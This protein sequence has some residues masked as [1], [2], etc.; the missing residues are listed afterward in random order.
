[1]GGSLSSQVAAAPGTE[2]STGGSPCGPRVAVV[3]IFLD[4]EDHLQE[5]IDSVFAQTFDRWEM[6]LVD[7]GSSDASPAIAKAA[8]A[9]DPVRVRYV[10]HDSEATRGM[11]A[12]RNLGIA[13]AVA[14]LIAYLDGDDV[15][16]PEKLER[17]LSLLDANPPARMVYGPL[18]RWRSWQHDRPSGADS[19]L[20]SL[21]VDDDLYGLVGD[22]SSVPA[23]TLFPP[24]ELPVR[25]IRD[26]DL[27]P[28]GALFERSLFE[29]VGR[30][31]EQFKENYEDAV[32]FVKMCLKAWVYCGP[33]AWYLYRQYPNAVI[34]E[35]HA[36]RSARQRE[37]GSQARARFI[38]WV[39]GYLS[40]EGVQEPQL[41]QAIMEAR[42][43][44]R[45]EQQSPVRSA[46]RSLIGSAQRSIRRIPKVVQFSSWY[47]GLAASGFLQR[48]PVEEITDEFA[49][50]H[51]ADGWNPFTAI[52]D[53]IDRD[54]ALP[55]DESSFGRFFLHPMVSGVRDLN[56]VLG[57]GGCGSPY[58]RLPRFWLGTYPW[59]G[60]SADA[61]GGE[62]PAFGWAHDEE[63]GAETS[64]LWG[65]GRTLWY[66]PSDR[67]TL[68][69]R[70]RET[71]ELYESIRRRYSPLRARGLPTV[72]MLRNDDGEQRAV[73][74]DG[75]HRIA[76][77]AHLGAKV[78]TCD[79]EATVDVSEA[80]HWP[81]V[82]SGYC[83]EDEARTIFNAFFELDGSERYRRIEERGVGGAR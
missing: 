3:V 45:A 83:T 6:I 54:P 28:S 16:L 18:I 32:V 65:Y 77:L 42:K 19:K 27:I 46:G 1:M 7:D 80:A 34:D 8:A 50:A 35:P 13:N 72:T 36:P 60:I 70:R 44:I 76:I 31:E 63:T 78:I 67:F 55:L 15:W 71:A 23:N 56:D 4:E 62:G 68:N 53:D 37:R 81:A 17:Q 79:V 33:L 57:L 10:R 66:R 11:S 43:Q 29:E 12:S 21:G 26:K 82:V 40:E 51:A 61:I 24:G 73:I 22:H 14:P 30:A 9:A 69:T 39:E 75:H 52:L 74:V 41:D 38:D 49:F 48:I 25:F 2:A 47:L 59:G 58:S 5:A 20:T 64:G